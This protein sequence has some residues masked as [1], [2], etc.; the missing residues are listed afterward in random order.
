MNH[1]NGSSDH[2]NGAVNGS[3]RAPAAESGGEQSS[4]LRRFWI[5]GATGFL[6]S[7]VVR[8]LI[9]R[10]DDLVA[11][12]RKGG[13]SSGLEVSAVDVLDVEAVAQSAAGC[14]GAF[15]ATGKVTRDKNAGEA[16]YEAHVTA[17]KNA[18]LGLRKAGVRRVV[19]ASTSGTIAVGSDPDEVYDEQH[20]A[21]L[22]LLAGWPYYRTKLY[23]E[24]A[25]LEA[26]DPSAFE[27]VVVNP[28]LLLGPGDLKES[29]TRDVRLFLEQ[30]IPA[31]PHGGMAF[32]DVRDAA[33]GM[34]A[35]FDRGRPGERYLLNGKNLTVAAFFQRLERLTGVPAPRV[36]LPRN[37][38]LALGLAKL[39][40]EALRK[41][42]GEPPVSEETV[43]MGTYYWYCSCEKAERELG[44]S[45]RDAG[46]TLRDTVQDLI[47]RKAAFPRNAINLAL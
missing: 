20:Q 23:A 33:A 8:A 7:H 29:S 14:D 43:E 19:V 40:N 24:R 34:L 44:F 30:A 5:G 28:S 18:L 10:G 25:A 26:N 36:K 6:G 42:G 32:V 3:G 31:V 4:G 41:L 38:T 47:S 45:A 16:L 39:A 1:D 9:E 17:T 37:R 13:S 15:L 2:T 35:A 22:S 21:P 12:S 27:V 46:E 11:V